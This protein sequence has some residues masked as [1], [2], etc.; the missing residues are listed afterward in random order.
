MR[1]EFRL[2]WTQRPA[3]GGATTRKGYGMTQEERTVHVGSLFG[4]Q[5]R[6]G[7]VELVVQGHAPIQLQTS[8]AR[9]I[10][11]MMLEAAEAADQ[12]A[13]LFGFMAETL[14]DKHASDDERVRLGAAM[15]HAYRAWR[16]DQAGKGEAK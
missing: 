10:A 9:E 2:Q 13:F 6:I 12:D 11:A 16:A 7:M 5:T 1:G 8:E 15:L 4:A 14:T 3:L